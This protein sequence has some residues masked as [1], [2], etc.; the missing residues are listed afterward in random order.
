MAL[1][2]SNLTK[3]DAMTEA[4]KKS[5]QTYY[6]S[7]PLPPAQPGTTPL[8]NQVVVFNVTN[9][10]AELAAPV[11]FAVQT[12]TT[13]DN[14]FISTAPPTNETSGTNIVDQITLEGDEIEVFS[15]AGIY[16]I[17]TLKITLA[18]RNV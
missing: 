14:L 6:L 7:I 3:K 12:G 11:Q 10:L 4:F 2:L 17:N 5:G 13:V 9:G 8:P 18:E 1:Q 15:V 16:L